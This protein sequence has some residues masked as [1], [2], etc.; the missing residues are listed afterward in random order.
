ML[1]STVQVR[2]T[3]HLYW[4]RDMMHT[5]KV[6][7]RFIVVTLS[8]T[9]VSWKA[10]SLLFSAPHKSLSCSLLFQLKNMR[11]CIKYIKNVR[12][13]PLPHP[14][15]LSVLSYYYYVVNVLLLLCSRK[16][17]L[18]SYMTSSFHWSN[19][20]A[21]HRIHL[22]LSD[23]IAHVWTILSHLHILHKFLFC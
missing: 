12:W 2:T 15:S 1:H 3:Q 19:C 6:Y 22:L 13:A 10:R 7:H 21:S 16:L 8:Y 5:D 14:L 18:T 17:P 4:V 20:C 11:C 9:N 23:I